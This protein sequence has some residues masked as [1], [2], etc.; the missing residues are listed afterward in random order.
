MEAEDKRGDFELTVMNSAGALQPAA[1]FH[2]FMRVVLTDVVEAY[3]VKDRELRQEAEDGVDLWLNLDTIEDFTQDVMLSVLPGL[4]V[5]WPLEGMFQ[6]LGTWILDNLLKQGT[7]LCEAVKNNDPNQLTRL[8][9]SGS[10]PNEGCDFDGAIALHYAAQNHVMPGI[11]KMVRQLLKAGANPNARTTDSARMMPL[12][13]AAQNGAHEIGV[14][15]L[16]AGAKID[17]RENNGGRPPI[18]LAAAHGHIKFVNLL[19]DRGA[20]AFKMTKTGGHYAMP[21]MNALDAAIVGK[22]YHDRADEMIARAS[23]M[24]KM[25]LMMSKSSSS[26]RRATTRR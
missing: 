10:D 14:L 17:A 9:A 20:D 3:K 5:P 23:E 25:Q 21:A 4:R 26:G 24:Q 19:V 13:H 15:L 18:V 1:S 12:H 16:N 8:L 22:N 2:Q 11:T 6:G 7:P